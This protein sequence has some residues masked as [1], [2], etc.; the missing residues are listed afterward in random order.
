MRKTPFAP[1]RICSTINSRKNRASL[2]ILGGCLCLASP[3]L[4]AQQ[5][6]GGQLS[7][8]LANESGHPFLSAVFRL[9]SSRDILEPIGSG[10][11]S[12]AVYTLQL[13]EPRAGLLSFLGETVVLEKTVSIVG[14][15]DFFE[16]VYVLEDEAGRRTTFTR[17]DDFVTAFASLSRYPLDEF[18]GDR[19]SAGS[20]LRLRVKVYPVQLIAPLTPIYLLSSSGVIESEW[21]KVGLHPSR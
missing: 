6:V 20:F 18:V 4:A 7:A 11:K 10:L 12:R 8:V 3:P 17:E 2:L 15:E 13:V 16:N 9:P 5:I 19:G 14:Y 21:V 1:S